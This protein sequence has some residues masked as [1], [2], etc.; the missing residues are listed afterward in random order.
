MFLQV[1]E[2]YLP[3]VF[4]EETN[5]S[6]K[7]S[8]RFDTSENCLNIDEPVAVIVEFLKS[9]GVQPPNQ[10][11]SGQQFHFSVEHNKKGP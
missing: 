2:V 5:Q 1:N 4:G 6:V 8:L 11:E 10:F 9:I 7:G 3:F